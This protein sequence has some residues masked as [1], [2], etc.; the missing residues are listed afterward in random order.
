M[1][2]PGSYRSV[3][4]A[5]ASC[6]ECPQ[7]APRR[8]RRAAHCT[9]SPESPGSRR[10]TEL[11]FHLGHVNRCTEI[12][13]LAPSV[14]EGSLL[15]ACAKRVAPALPYQPRT[16]DL[17]RCRDDTTSWP[18]RVVAGPTLPI[19]GLGRER[20]RLPS[21]LGRFP[22][23]GPLGCVEI[24]AYDDTKPT[25]VLGAVKTLF[26]VSAAGFA[27]HAGITAASYA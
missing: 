9:A 1:K 15:G 24:R 2:V 22:P 13:V 11:L 17:T 23:V 7:P 6:S 18:R 20:V 5:W 19:A 8:S 26:D 14:L 3:A 25:D 21:G 12:L 16:C 27:L 10:R 4:N